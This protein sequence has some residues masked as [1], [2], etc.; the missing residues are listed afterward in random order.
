MERI[1][2]RPVSPVMHSPKED[3][4]GSITFQQLRLP[5]PLGFTVLVADLLALMAAASVPSPIYHLYQDRLAFATWVLT[6]IFAVYAVVLLGTLLTAGSLSDHIGRRPVLVAGLILQAGSTGL[7]W[8]A[9]D[10]GMLLV[11]RILQ[12]LSTGVALGAVSAAMVD[13]TP[14]RF[15]TLGTTLASAGLGIGLAIGAVAVGL[16]GQWTPAPDQ[17]VFPLLTLVLIILA[18]LSAFVPG[19][20]PRKP[21]ALASLWPAVGIAAPLRP[22]F[23]RAFPGIAAGWA[24]MGLFMAL[25]P[26]IVRAD[27]HADPT[28][29]GGYIIALLAI[30]NAVGAVGTA[31]FAPAI[32][33]SLGPALM[34]LGMAWTLFSIQLDLLPLHFVAAAFA[35]TG[36]GASFTS[37]LR[38]ISAATPATHRAQTMSAV[39]V[40][41]YLSLSV[42]ALG[43]G[44]IATEAGLATAVEIY[45]AGV[46]ILAAAAAVL[47]SLDGTRSSGTHVA[48]GARETT[49]A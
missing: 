30:F 37:A 12:G 5:R 22:V 40:L 48:G 3:P 16:V 27:F 47:A 45:G 31:R 13:L 46:M 34:V 8:A 43:A 15:P 26:S 11:A 24:I 28:V 7:F 9:S 42:P 23:A 36:V 20:H 17:W 32:G 21:G 18:M 4:M 19:V 41:S 1:Y 35:G 38:S 39:Y 6:L 33:A 25:G 49:A 29:A 44:I 10:V 14:R 2:R